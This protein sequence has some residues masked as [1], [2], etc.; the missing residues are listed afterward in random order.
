MILL[1]YMG[2]SELKDKCTELENIIMEHK[3]YN[4]F[5]FKFGKFKFDKFNGLTE[6]KEAFRMHYGTDIINFYKSYRIYLLCKYLLFE[7]KTYEM[8]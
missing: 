5:S 2:I 3:S 1:N 8:P 4:K 6:F 7:G